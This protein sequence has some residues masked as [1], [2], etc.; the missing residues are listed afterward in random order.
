MPSPQ[1]PRQ[2]RCVATAHL[3]F[4]AARTGLLP[5]RA[6]DDTPPTVTLGAARS[7]CNGQWQVGPVFRNLANR[8]LSDHGCRFP[9]RSTETAQTTTP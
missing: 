9:P 7:H 6:P 3:I 2:P 1:F 4:S 8:T 5:I